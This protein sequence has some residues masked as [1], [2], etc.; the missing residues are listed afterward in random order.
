MSRSKTISEPNSYVPA[1]QEAGSDPAL[2]RQH[3]D[4]H[5]ADINFIYSIYAQESTDEKWVLKRPLHKC[6]TSFLPEL[7]DY[8]REDGAIHLPINDLNYYPLIPR[9]H[10]S[11]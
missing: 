1:L 11:A 3:P 8:V 10:D 9:A 6:Y 5:G 7:H 2:D 4:C